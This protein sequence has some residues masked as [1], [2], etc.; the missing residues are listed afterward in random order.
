MG[1]HLKNILV[2]MR[3]AFVLMPEPRDYIYPDRGGF[4]RDAANL[5]S[6]F[7][8]LGRDMRTVLKRDESSNNRP[9]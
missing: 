2:G 1:K 7:T 5:R 6:D 9:R 3:Q 4:A 8:V